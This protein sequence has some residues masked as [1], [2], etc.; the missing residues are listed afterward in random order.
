MAYDNDPGINT[1]YPRI[2]Y[3]LFIGSNSNDIGHL[4]FKL[5]TKYIWTTMKYQPVPVPDDLLKTNSKKDSFTTK[6]QINHF[7]SDRFTA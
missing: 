1:L 2:F 3:E 4:I 6:I 7:D 5:S